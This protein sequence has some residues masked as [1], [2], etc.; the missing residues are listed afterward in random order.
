MAEMDWKRCTRCG[1][2]GAFDAFPPNRR[3]RDGLSSWCRRCHAEAVQRWRDENSEKAPLY[4]LAG[5]VKHEP[6]PCVE[7][8]EPFVPGRSDAELCSDLCRWRR[9]RRQRK[10]AA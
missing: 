2:T 10:A 6:R 4:N 8:G 9:S 5:R 7:C 1:E 3:L